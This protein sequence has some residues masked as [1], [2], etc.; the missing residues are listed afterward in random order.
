MVVFAVFSLVFLVGGWG[1]SKERVA[2]AGDGRFSWVRASR[3]GGRRIWTSFFL[4]S[5]WSTFMG[6]FL[7]FGSLTFRWRRWVRAWL[8]RFLRVLN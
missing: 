1:G 5:S 2:E 7:A 4:M 3:S 8:D 6:D